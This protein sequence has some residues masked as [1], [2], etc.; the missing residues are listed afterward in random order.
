MNRGLALLG[1]CLLAAALFIQYLA[2]IWN[3][4]Y[5]LFLIPFIGSF[6]AGICIG[7]AKSGDIELTAFGGFLAAGSACVLFWFYLTLPNYL[8]GIRLTLLAS[9]LVFIA[10]VMVEK[11]GKRY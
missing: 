3:E 1:G 2:I 5:T 11:S 8:E 10:M 6:L 7:G 9:I 4:N